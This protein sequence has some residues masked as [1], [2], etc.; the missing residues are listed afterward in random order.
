MQYFR[1]TRNIDNKTALIKVDDVKMIEPLQDGRKLRR[2]S[3]AMTRLNF[4]NLEFI[5][6]NESI[7]DLK[8]NII[9]LDQEV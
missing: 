6:I 8:Y 4:N 9:N 3:G 5:D 1:I 2:R 7:N